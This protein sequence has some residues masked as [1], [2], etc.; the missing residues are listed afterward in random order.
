MECGVVVADSSVVTA[1]KHLQA[2]V[3]VVFQEHPGQIHAI[4]LCI[5]FAEHN[6]GKYAGSLCN[7]RCE[8]KIKIARVK[9]S[10]GARHKTVGSEFRLALIENLVVDFSEAAPLNPLNVVY[11]FDLPDWRIPRCGCRGRLRRLGTRECD[12]S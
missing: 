3:V 10:C 7:P 8:K 1:E 9:A 6:F 2:I 12:I 4:A 11:P 5:A